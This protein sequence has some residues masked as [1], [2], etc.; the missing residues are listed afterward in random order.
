MKSRIYQTRQGHWHGY[1]GR[2]KVIEFGIDSVAAAAWLAD[3]QH[4]VQTYGSPHHPVT[5]MPAPPGYMWVQQLFTG[6]WL[7]ENN[8]TPYMA[9]VASETY[10][11]S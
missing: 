1:R 11:S 2:N 10:W 4:P 5:G 8:R 9:S 7:L 3:Q 6:E